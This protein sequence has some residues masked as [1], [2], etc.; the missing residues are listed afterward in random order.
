MPFRA[1]PLKLDEEEQDELR[2]MTLS[3]SLPAGDVFR[4]RLILM[5]AQGRSYSEIQERLETTP[6]T[7]S[8]WKARFEKER[9]EGLTLIRHPGKK[10]TVITPKLQAR[11]LE[12]TRR[13]PRDGSTHWSCRKLAEHLRISKDAV[14]RIWRAAGIRP[15]RL[16]RYLASDDPD[17]EKKAADIIGLYLNPPLHAAIFCVDEKSAI[18]ALDRLDPVLPMSPGRAERNTTGME[19]SPCMRLLT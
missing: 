13:K 14:H 12:A 16:E 1:K 9:I 17:F 7:I 18:Q 5:L 19:L 15:H 4:A 10:A 2:Q 3:R 8:L 6:P 11:V